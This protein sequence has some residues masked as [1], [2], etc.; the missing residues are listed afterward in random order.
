LAAE[1]FAQKN[2]LKFPKIEYKDINKKAVSCFWD[3]DS[4]SPMIIYMPFVKDI[5]LNYSQNPIL[6]N[7]DP[8]NCISS[9]FCGTYNFG[10]SQY[11]FEQ[12][13]ELMRCNVALNKEIIK[14][15]I[16]EFIKIKNNTETI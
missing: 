8:N 4:L 16:L 2:N 12:V 10:Y 1:K 7:F 6:K 9:A 5:S 11:Q 14:N 13:C 3:K 15:K